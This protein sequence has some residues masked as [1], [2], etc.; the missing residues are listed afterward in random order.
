MKQKCEERTFWNSFCGC[1]FTDTA[2]KRADTASILKMIFQEQKV[3]ILIMMI[4]ILKLY[5][6]NL[7]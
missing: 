3:I 6:N 2:T 1:G 5:S 4:M 7:D